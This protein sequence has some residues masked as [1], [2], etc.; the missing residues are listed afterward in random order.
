MQLVRM[1]RNRTIFFPYKKCKVSGPREIPRNRIREMRTWITHKKTHL[2]RLFLVLYTDK[3]CD[4]SSDSIVYRCYWIRWCVHVIHITHRWHIRFTGTDSHIH[5]L[6]I[7]H[8]CSHT[9]AAR[10]RVPEEYIYL[11]QLS[12]FV[13]SVLFTDIYSITYLYRTV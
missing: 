13:Q 6:S 4:P 1:V 5:A 10:H 7:A 12:K 11:N 8:T 2:F 3:S 9:C